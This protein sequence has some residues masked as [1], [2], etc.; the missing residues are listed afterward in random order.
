MRTLDELLAAANS[1][2]ITYKTRVDTARKEYDD[3]ASAAEKAK[4]AQEKAVSVGDAAAFEAAKK[5]EEYNHERAKALAKVQADP[6]Y[7]PAEYNAIVEEIR[8][9]YH[10]ECAGHYQKIMEAMAKILKESAAVEQVWKKANHVDYVLAQG[11]GRPLSGR[12]SISYDNFREHPN[13]FIRNL[14]GKYAV[15]RA[16]IG[17]LASFGG[18]NNDKG[19]R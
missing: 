9:G 1:A 4:V 7:S 14:C 6:L 16:H 5:T 8:K 11:V 3:A 10:A 2:A 12:A 15:E 18:K 13:E 19:G 17:R